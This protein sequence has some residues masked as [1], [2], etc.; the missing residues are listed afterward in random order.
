MEKKDI[1]KNSYTYSF[2]T[3]KSPNEIFELLLGVENWWIGIYG[4]TI[5]GFSKKVGDEFSF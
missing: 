3:I 4:E 2:N 1:L 5:T